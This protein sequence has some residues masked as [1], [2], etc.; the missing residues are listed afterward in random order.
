MAPRGRAETG[1]GRGARDFATHGAANHEPAAVLT[2][3]MTLLRGRRPGVCGRGAA[4]DAVADFLAVRLYGR[5]SQKE[6]GFIIVAHQ[7]T[8]LPSPIS[9]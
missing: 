2:S 6:E 5:R 9:W 3:S 7:A 4:S 1:L 8:L